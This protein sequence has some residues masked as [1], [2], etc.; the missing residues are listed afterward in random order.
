MSPKEIRGQSIEIAASLGYA[1]NPALPL[2]EGTECS[3]TGSEI[4][5]RLLALHAVAATALGFERER[6]RAWLT[7]ERVWEALPRQERRFIDEGTG[8]H[9]R[10]ATAVEAMWALA[11]AL[12]LI[13]HLDF[14]LGCDDQ[15]VRKMPDLKVG[16][17]SESLRTKIHLRPRDELLSACDLAYCLHWAIREAEIAG[18]GHLAR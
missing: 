4:V 15:F 16:Q 8:H 5:D 9:H 11:W 3:R 7:K 13:E 12:G 18:K 10:F 2:P 17:S 14:S 1:T 6:A